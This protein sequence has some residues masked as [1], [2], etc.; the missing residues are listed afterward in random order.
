M[1]GEEHWYCGIERNGKDELFRMSIRDENNNKKTVEKS[2]FTF[3][4]RILCEPQWQVKEVT[5]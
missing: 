5:E 1:L 4:C 2:T 3:C